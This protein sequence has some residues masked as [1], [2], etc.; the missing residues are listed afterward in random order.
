MDDRNQQQ[1]H[2]VLQLLSLFLPPQSAQFGV[3]K[4]LWDHMVRNGIIL[5]TPGD[6]EEVKRQLYAGNAYSSDK[7]YLKRLKT[8]YSDQDHQLVLLPEEFFPTGIGIAIRHG[9]PYS[10]AF[11]R[12]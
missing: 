7:S 9:A 12:T 8:M 5:M 1:L 6:R 10:K 3:Y 11:S 2:F 4:R